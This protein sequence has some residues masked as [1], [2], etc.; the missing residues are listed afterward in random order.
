MGSIFPSNGPI[1][2]ATATAGQVFEMFQ[3]ADSQPP[4]SLQKADSQPASTID[5]LPGLEQKMDT[6]QKQQ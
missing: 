6:I 1:A 5:D 4:A 2:Q 3:N